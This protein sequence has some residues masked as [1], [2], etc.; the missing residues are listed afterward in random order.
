MYPKLRIEI[1]EKYDAERFHTFLYKYW[2]SDLQSRI[3]WKYK[4]VFETVLSL[5]EE[6]SEKEVHRIVKDLYKKFDLTL[7]EAQERF[8]NE[9]DKIFESCIKA[10]V[11]TMSFDITKVKESYRWVL[12]LLPFSPFDIDERTFSTSILQPKIKENPQIAIW[13]AIHEISHFFFQN[14]LRESE[15][16]HL[17]DFGNWV[18]YVIKESITPV[19]MRNWELWKYFPYSKWNPNIEWLMIDWFD[20]TFVDWCEWIYMKYDWK[21]NLFAK[22]IIRTA[23]LIEDV[24]IERKTHWD[25]AFKFWVSEEIKDKE[26]SAFSIPIK[27]KQSI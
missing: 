8:Q 20:W 27:I 14:W 6:E 16:N 17:A 11:E 23:L 18:N 21:F 5:N 19:L 24:L 9:A 22:E 13:T 12:T 1:D 3:L 2:K 4:N 25:N 10:L 26:L 15:F 7:K